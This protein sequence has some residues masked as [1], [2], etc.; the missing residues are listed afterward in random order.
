[1]N[2]KTKINNPV[3]AYDLLSRYASE[4][5]DHFIVL[6]L[7]GAHQVNGQHIVTIGLA[8]RTLVHPREVF[9]PAIVDNAVAIIVAHNH[10]SGQILPSPEDE[11]IT[12]RLH[13]AGEILGIPVLD[14]IIIGNGRYYSFAEA[15]SL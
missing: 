7:D 5:Q 11:Q 15:G 4:R 10:P 2:E 14:H 12:Q 1:M 8:N 9:Y 13:D 6:T 3:D